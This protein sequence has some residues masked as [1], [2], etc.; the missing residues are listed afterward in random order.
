MKSIEINDEDYSRLKKYAEPFE[1]DVAS[2][3]QKVLDALESDSTIE[4]RGSIAPSARS[5]SLVYD[6]NNI[7]S[8][9]HSRLLSAEFAGEAPEKANWNSLVE[10][11]LVKL[12]S[13]LPGLPEMKRVA[14]IN[15]R[16]GE[17]TELG[18]RPFLE[19]RYSFQG[20]SSDSA[21]NAVVKIAQRLDAQFSVEFEWHNHPNAACPGRKGKILRDSGV[22]EVS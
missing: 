3:F 18:Y 22:G 20:L 6:E 9:K 19:G 8:L 16:E 10:L 15:L 4:M 1:D 17:C 13:A 11:A 21:I 5:T 2:T 12:A 7:P 14:R